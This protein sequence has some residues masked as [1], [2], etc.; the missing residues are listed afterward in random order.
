MAGQ[1]AGSDPQ[2]QYVLG[3]GPCASPPEWPRPHG[4]WVSANGVSGSEEDAHGD[5]IRGPW[6]GTAACPPAM[7]GGDDDGGARVSSKPKDCRKM[8]YAQCGVNFQLVDEH[9]DETL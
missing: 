1:S 6:S 8:G 7:S 3:W 2:E 5:A 9:H 4:A